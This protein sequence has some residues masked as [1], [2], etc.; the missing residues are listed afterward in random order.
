MKRLLLLT[1]LATIP[2]GACG[3][4]LYDGTGN[5]EPGPSYWPWVC[6]DGG[7]VDAEG[8]CPE[9]PTCPDGGAADDADGG[10]P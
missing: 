9:L 6:P 8:G 3:L 10:C 5:P 7:D 2:L 4:G 1:A